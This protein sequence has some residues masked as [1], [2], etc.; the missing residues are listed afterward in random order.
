MQIPRCP[1][2]LQDSGVFDLNR[3]DCAAGNFCARIPRRLGGEIIWLA[4][5]NDG[6]P[7]DFRKGDLLRKKHHPGAS[8]VA[9]KRRQ[10]ACMGR[11]GAVGGV[12]MVLGVRIGV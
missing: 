11:V 10:V 5:D 8:I 9:K 6:F 7:Q 4:V 2:A 12:V 3:D 1:A